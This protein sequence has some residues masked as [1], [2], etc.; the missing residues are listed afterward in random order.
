MLVA[1]IAVAAGCGSD[2]GDADDDSPAARGPVTA[3]RLTI[4]LA[5]DSG[6]LNIFA[7]QSPAI[8]DLVY[9]KLLAPSPYVDQ[10]QPWLA[11]AVRQVDP[12]TWEVDLRDDVR[13]QDGEPFDATDVAFS[14][15][16][17]KRAPT[18]TY[19]HHVSDIPTIETISALSPTQVRFSCAF[20]CPELG[21]VTLADLPVIPEHVW[22]SVPPEQ[23]KEVTALPVG[24]GPYRLVSYDSTAGYRFEANPDYFAGEPVV[25]ELVMPVISDPSATFT[26]LRSGEVDATTRPLSPELID[27]FTASSDVGIV[28]TAPL[29][30][31]ELRLNYDRA[32]FDQPAFR[33][34]LS[35]AVDRDQLLRVVGLGKGRAAVKGYPHPDAP[36]ANA[37]LSTPYAP[38]EAA[39]ALDELGMRDGD[40]DGLREGPDGPLSF[41]VYAN[42]AA[43]LDVR[44]AELVAEDLREVGIDATAEA[45]DAGSVADLSKSRDFDL[46]INNIGPHGVADPTQFIMSHRSGYLWR[47]PKLPYPEWDALFGRWKATTTIEDRLGVL[48]EMQALFNRQP[49][50]IPLYYP[51]EYWAFQPDRFAGWVESPGYGIVHKWS[52]LP[53]QVGR[54]A[55]AVVATAR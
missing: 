12:S 1:T 22:G 41:T 24:T 29:R 5:K 17:F 47:A 10:P 48:D 15:D 32:P 46:V 53:P 38:D 18:G 36:F 54:D 9:D 49:T 4:A 45:L 39:V 19:T 13:W 37:A 35:R 16:Y 14:F 25:Q 8:D 40:G 6:P 3:E 42:G 33:S 11:T 23:A 20:P 31:P 30:F 55:G 52:L 34:A 21:T 43:P 44:S 27:R 2:G 7:D 50:S 51:D 28:K 26:A